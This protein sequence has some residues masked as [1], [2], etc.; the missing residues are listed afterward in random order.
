MLIFQHVNLLNIKHE[1]KVGM[2]NDF[3]IR[4]VILIMLNM[5]IKRKFKKKVSCPNFELD[6]PYFFT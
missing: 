5:I 2:Q 3:Q 1:R 4:T 6:K